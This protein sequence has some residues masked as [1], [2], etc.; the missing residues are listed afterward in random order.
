MSDDTQLTD[1]VGNALLPFEVDGHAFYIRQPSPEEY[2]E[3][4]TLQRMTYN[5]TLQMPHI[6]EVADMPCSEGERVLF[7]AMLDDAQAKFDAADDGPAKRTLA[8]E[9]ARLQNELKGRTLAEETASDAAA[10][11]RDRWLCAHLLCDKDG[12]PYFNTTAKTF[13][14]RWNKLPLKVKNEA[15]PVIWQALTL[16][17]EAPFASDL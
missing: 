16:V 8:D 1:A 7:Q 13:E 4:M 3:A 15:R 2:D 17:R 9:I 12:K 11:R 6:K 5:K 14:A 10:L